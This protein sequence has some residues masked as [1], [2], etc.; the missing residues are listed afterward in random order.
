MGYFYYRKID[1]Q[2]ERW[3]TSRSR[4]RVNERKKEREKRGRKRNPASIEMRFP[5]TL[6]VSK[7]ISNRLLTLKIHGDVDFPQTR[8]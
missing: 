6:V 4:E 8:V 7:D 1:A 2:S 5:L 3:S